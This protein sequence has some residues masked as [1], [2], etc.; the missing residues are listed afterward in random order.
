MSNSKRKELPKSKEVQEMISARRDQIK[1]MFRNPKVEELT[2]T[3]WNYMDVSTPIEKL[4]KVDFGLVLGSADMLPAVRAVELYDAGKVSRF[5]FSGKGGTNLGL[6]GNE[7][8]ARALSNIA[9]GLGVHPADVILEQES[10]NTGQ[11]I[12]FTYNLLKGAQT[13]LREGEKG[14]SF[15]LVPELVVLHMP[16]ALGRDRATLMKQWPSTE[17]T[18]QPKF[19][20]SGLQIGMIGYLEQ[21]FGK[22]QTVDKI[23]GGLL[24][25]FQRMQVCVG[26]PKNERNW[27]V[28]VEVH[29]GEPTPLTVKDAYRELVDRGIGLDSLIRD[30]TAERKPL[31]I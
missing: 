8:E 9:T 16:S 20:M 29:Y 13:T 21:G 19:Y 11:N 26:P 27:M 2:R 15:I 25:D 1:E 31:A 24:G 28:P 30:D 14:A 10:T 12:Q 22:D 7:T 17:D 5:V 18:P 3:V 23:I 4:P 6:S